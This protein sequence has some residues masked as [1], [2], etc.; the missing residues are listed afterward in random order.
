MDE[1]KAALGPVFV[2]LGPSGTNHELV[3]QNYLSFRGFE[4]ITLI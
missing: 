1:L 3:T 4:Q 2:T